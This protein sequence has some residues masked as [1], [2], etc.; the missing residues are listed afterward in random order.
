MKKDGTTRLASGAQMPIIGF[1][2][3][4]APDG[5]IAYNAVAQALRAGYRHIDTASI[6]RN[7]TAVGSAIRDSKDSIS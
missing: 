4:Q 3:W 6:Y 7:E 1:G 2:T 5:E